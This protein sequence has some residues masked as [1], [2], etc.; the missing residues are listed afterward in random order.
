MH[1][2]HRLA[3]PG[4]P[5][6]LGSHV[7]RSSTGGSEHVKLL[8]VHDARQAKVSDQQVGVIFGRAEQQILGLQVSMDNA[9]VVEIGNSGQGRADK[10]CSIRLVVVALS[11]DAIEELA[12]QRQVGYKVHCRWSVLQSGRVLVLILVSIQLFIVSK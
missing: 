8:L 9:V 10:V 1:Y 3:V 5:E 2:S 12:S 7:S 4:F 6:D 11:A